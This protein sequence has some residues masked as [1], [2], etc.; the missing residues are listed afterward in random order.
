MVSRTY[1]VEQKIGCISIFCQCLFVQPAPKFLAGS[2][3]IGS[4]LIIS[5]NELLSFALASLHN[6]VVCLYKVSQ[7]VPKCTSFKQ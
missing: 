6:M 1:N 4:L 5:E 2:C 7:E 3:P